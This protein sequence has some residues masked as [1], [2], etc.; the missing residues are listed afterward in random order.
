MITG[1]KSQN[2][3]IGKRVLP[4]KIVGTG[5]VQ[6]Y[7]STDLEE[8]WTT[9]N[10]FFASHGMEFRVENKIFFIFYKQDVTQDGTYEWAF[11]EDELAVFYQVGNIQYPVFGVAL[12]TVSESESRQKLFVQG[13]YHDTSGRAVL[14]YAEGEGKSTVIN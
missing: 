5:T 9:D 11:R 13:Y 4:M 3:Q 8:E 12:L 2:I 10:L 14:I 7:R 1:K 6:L